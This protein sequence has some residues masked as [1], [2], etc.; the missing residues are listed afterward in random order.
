M[1]FLGFLVMIIAVMV[2]VQRERKE[3]SGHRYDPNK[4]EAKQRTTKSIYPLICYPFIYLIMN[5]PHLI[6]NVCQSFQLTNDILAVWILDAL[7][8]P[9]AGG[10]MLLAYTFDSHT[11]KTLK[12][13][14][15][16]QVVKS[17]F[18]NCFRTC[19]EREWTVTDYHCEAE[20]PI[21]GI[22]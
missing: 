9:L 8:T 10:V 11:R 7:L 5:L 22:V 6:G 20:K 16:R 18:K 1:F 21:L 4:M 15:L 2:K 17:C 12:K 3:Y 19:M 14:S 13:G